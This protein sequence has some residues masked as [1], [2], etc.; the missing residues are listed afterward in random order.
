MFPGDFVVMWC[1]CAA[2]LYVSRH[3]CC[4]D[5]VVTWR[6]CA[7]LLYVSVRFCCVDFVVM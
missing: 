4:V 6:F 2:L 3:F 1:F 7:A 5:F